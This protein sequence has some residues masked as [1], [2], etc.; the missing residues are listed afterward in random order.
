[1]PSLARWSQLFAVVLLVGGLAASC[2]C[3]GSKSGGRG[4]GAEE[5]AGAPRRGGVVTMATAL[6]ADNFDPVGLSYNPSIWA[7]LN[8]HDQLVRTGKDG[9]SV[10]PGLAESWETSQDGRVYTFHLRPS[11]KFSDGSALRASDVRFS[12]TRL[13]TEGKSSWGFLFPPLAIE[14]PDD[15]TVVIKLEAPWAPLLADL[16][17]FAASIIPEAYYKNVGREGFGRAPIGSGPFVLAEWRKGERV[18]LR[19]NPHYWDTGHP[20]LDEVRL[21][22]IEDANTRMLKI[23]AGEVEIAE[24]VPFNQIEGVERAPGVTVQIAPI[25]KVD[26]IFLNQRSPKLNDKKIRQAIGWGIDREAIIRAVLFGHGR[27][28]TSFLPPMLYTDTEAPPFR[29]DVEKARALVAESS[30]PGGLPLRLV[31]GASD[32]SR[33]IATLIKSQLEPIGIQVEIQQYERAAL[34]ARVREGDFD[35]RLGVETSDIVDPSQMVAS[36]AVGTLGLTAASVG[37][38]NPKVNELAAAAQAEL[39]PRRRAELYR[40]IQQIVREDAPY[41]PLYWPPA[42]TAVREGVHGFAI[43]PTAN[44]R[45]WEVWRSR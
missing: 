14:T 8:V 21:L 43:L 6:N 15:R 39:D 24:E 28:P 26:L 25:Q 16:A 37:Y 5:D 36:N 1:M 22:Q 17:L 18:V 45:L 2:T 23:Q 33:Q 29:R 27:V 34:Q 13:V 19:R 44:Y 9:Q 32:H 11:L 35:M 3:G 41:V 42:V 20:Y 30:S 31:I 4:G 38:D 40:E 7:M 12:L 10:E